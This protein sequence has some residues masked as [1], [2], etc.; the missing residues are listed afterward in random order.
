M[1]PLLKIEEVWSEIYDVN[2]LCA[3]GDTGISQY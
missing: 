1:Y 2:Y 3:L